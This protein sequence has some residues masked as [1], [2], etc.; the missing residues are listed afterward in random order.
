MME[1][2]RDRFL[3]QPEDCQAAEQAKWETSSLCRLRFVSLCAF[4]PAGFVVQV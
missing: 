2:G 3:G 1:N 4:S